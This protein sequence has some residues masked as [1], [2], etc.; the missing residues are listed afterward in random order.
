[1]GTFKLITHVNFSSDETASVQNLETSL[2]S[3]Q[4]SLADISQCT[5]SDVDQLD[6]NATI[7]DISQQAGAELEPNP[8]HR[9]PVII[10]EFRNEQ[11]I[12]NIGRLPTRKTIRRNNIVLQSME[13]PVVMNLN[14]RS[15]YNKT[16]D[17]YVLLEQY[18]ADVVCISES[19]ERDDFTLKELLDLENFEVI[20]NVKQRDFKGGKPAIIVNKEKYHVKKLCPEPITVP[21]GVEAV[22]A[23]ITPKLLS[24]RS[25]A[26]YIAIAS[27]YYRGPKSTKKDELFDHI[28]QSF[29]FLSA[30]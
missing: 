21:V 28:A 9:I 17:F 4:N 26:K 8:N 13:L 12:R 25:K 16:E 22:W 23:L 2:H 15:I 20:T 6:G 10:S 29:H 24:K 5:V 7:F 14:P 18:Q 27:I 3:V 30:R 11:P 19:W 1:M